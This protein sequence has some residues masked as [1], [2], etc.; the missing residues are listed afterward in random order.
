MVQQRFLF[1]TDCGR[2]YQLKN[3]AQQILFEL[4][5][6]GLLNSQMSIL[7]IKLAVETTEKVIRQHHNE[8]LVYQGVWNHTTPVALK[9]LKNGTQSEEFLKEVI[10]LTYTLDLNN[11]ETLEK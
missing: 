10:A 9:A 8:Y 4:K 11:N 5:L 1:G 7:S 3:E 6:R 2:S